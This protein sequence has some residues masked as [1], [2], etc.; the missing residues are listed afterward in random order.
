MCCLF[1]ELIK[2][3]IMPNANYVD[4][5]IILKTLALL[6]ML[7][8]LHVEREVISVCR[9]GTSFTRP[10][11]LSNCLSCNVTCLLSVQQKLPHSSKRRESY[12][13]TRPFLLNIAG[14]ILVYLFPVQ[15]A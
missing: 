9:T 3:F 7:T 6:R 2:Q 12:K 1:L 10:N 11:A 14:A 4:V 13:I 15:R 8:V 5:K